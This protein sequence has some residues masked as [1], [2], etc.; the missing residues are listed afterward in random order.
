MVE[1]EP[2]EPTWV[3]AVEPVPLSANLERSLAAPLA[4]VTGESTGVVTLFQRLRA[5]EKGPIV[6]VED[7]RTKIYCNELQAMA[8]GAVSVGALNT[9][10]RLLEPPSGFQWP[11]LPLDSS[12]LAACQR[13]VHAEATATTSRRSNSRSSFG[14]RA[15]SR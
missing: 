5:R 7:L 8:R 10:G 15:W 9:L 3:L 6:T 11:K 13:S 1:P 14:W 12:V 2:P 4:F